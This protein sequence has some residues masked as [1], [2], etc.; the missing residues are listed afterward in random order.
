MTG[1]A[2]GVPICRKD[3]SFM[4]IENVMKYAEMELHGDTIEKRYTGFKR[5]SPRGIEYD[6]SLNWIAHLAKE[7]IMKT[8]AEYRFQAAGCHT[9][10]GRNAL[11]KRA[12]DLEND[13]G[14]FLITIF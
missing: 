8:V 13:F 3:V 6:I 11:L 1:A 7:Q 4:K 5:V 12:D 14:K 2:L 10:E 9:I